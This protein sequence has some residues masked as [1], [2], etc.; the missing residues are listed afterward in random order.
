MYD[1]KYVLI[2]E[3]ET[4]FYNLLSQ[5]FCERNPDYFIVT[6]RG[7]GDYITKKFL[8][9]LLTKLPHLIF[10]YL[11]DFDYHGQKI[12]IDYLFGSPF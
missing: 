4:I 2:I 6:A 9:N 8:K 3:K 12:Y 5:N 1:I 10:F 11:G 7:Y